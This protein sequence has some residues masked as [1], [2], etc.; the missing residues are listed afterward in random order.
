[1]L[2][3]TRLAR[4]HFYSETACGY[5]IWRIASA[6][7]ATRRTT[8]ILQRSADSGAVHGVEQWLMRT[9]KCELSE[10]SEPYNESKVH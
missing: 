3:R 7:H 2:T 5:W 1:M 6:D 4:Y 8:T 9:R 10:P